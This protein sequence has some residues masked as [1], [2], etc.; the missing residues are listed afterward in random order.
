MPRLH[1]C[2]HHRRFS[3]AAVIIGEDEFA[4]GKA[5]IK[6]LSAHTDTSGPACAV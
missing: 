5:T 4:A 1:P 2:W 6:D 3:P